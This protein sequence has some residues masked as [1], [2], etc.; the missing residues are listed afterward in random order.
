MVK[1]MRP[2]H[3]LWL[4]PQM[5][6]SDSAVK[7]EI[8]YCDNLKKHVAIANYQVYTIDGINDKGS[9]FGPAMY[10][11][12]LVFVSDRGPDMI[13]FEKSGVTGSNFFKMYEAKPT[14]KNFTKPSRFSI[15]ING[16][17]LAILI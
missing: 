10:N 7:N 3:S 2:V 15:P 14:D 8:R 11:D 9:D 17:N 4:D 5:A 1:W 16:A 13:E 12:N 6:P